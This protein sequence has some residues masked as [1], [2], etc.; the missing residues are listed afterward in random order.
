MCEYGFIEGRDFN[1][2]KIERVQREG[3]RDVSREVTDHRLTIGMAKEICMLQRTEIGKRCREYF[4]EIE[5]RYYEHVKALSL[6]EFLFEQAKLML[7]HGRRLSV[8]EEK[9]EQLAAKAE[10]HPEG[11]YTIAGYAS[12]KGLKMDVSKANTLGRKAAKLSREY[13]YDVSKTPDPRF[14]TVNLY[15]EGIL[16]KVFAEMY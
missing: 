5:Q 7:E 8:V 11:Y 15:Y 4:L 6:E 10:T 2:L 12:L 1:L 3:D 13:G 14:G 9:V 16:E